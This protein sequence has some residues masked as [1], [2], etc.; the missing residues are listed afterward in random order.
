[1]RHTATLLS[2]GKVLV[3]GGLSA[4]LYDPA[5]GIW[6]TMG[7]LITARWAHTATLLPNGKVLIAAGYGYDSLASAELYEPASGMWTATGALNTARGFGHTMTLL[8]NGKTLLVGGA[9]PET[10]PFPSAELYD[11]NLGFSTSW[12]PQIATVTSPL[13]PGGSLTVTGSGFRGVSEGASGVTQGSA[14]DYPLVQLRGLESG[15]ALF[16]CST[17]WQTN[18]FTSAPVRG[19]LP[20]W[21]LATVFVNGIPSAAGMLLVTN[22]SLAAL[23][24][25]NLSQTYDGTARRSPASLRHRAWPSASPT[26]VRPMRPPTSAVTP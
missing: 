16:L 2:N 23:T 7:A 6:T 4:E 13:S 20:G 1:M 11:L 25:T 9:E 10:Y 5:S 24:L 21:A 22:K 17:N 12:Q 18:S 15:Q 8:P 14:C 19:F 26:T 3:V